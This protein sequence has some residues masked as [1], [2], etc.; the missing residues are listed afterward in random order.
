MPKQ[1]QVSDEM[2]VIN[3][4]V[5]NGDH[6]SALPFCKVYGHVHVRPFTVDFQSKCRS[7]AKSLRP[8]GAGPGPLHVVVLEHEAHALHGSK[9][10]RL[11]VR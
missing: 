10:Q 8:P 6:P 4:D 5:A 2:V 3:V 7:K 1:V 9:L 11:A